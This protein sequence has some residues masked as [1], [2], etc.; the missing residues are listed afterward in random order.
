M[1]GKLFYIISYDIAKKPEYFEKLRDNFKFKIIICDES[2]YLKGHTSLRFKNLQ[3]L[4]SQARRILLLTG[5]PLIS[6]PKDLFNPLSLIRPDLFYNF[7]NFAKQF[8]GLTLKQGRYY[9][10][11]GASNLKQLA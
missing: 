1:L 8:C 11:N 7:N 6:R 10:C 4:L 5:T 2:H 3:P 9:D